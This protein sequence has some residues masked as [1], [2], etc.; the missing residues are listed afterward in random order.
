WCV[1]DGADPW[2][3]PSAAIASFECLSGIVRSELPGGGF[4]LPG[5]PFFNK[6]TQKGH[7]SGWPLHLIDAWQFPTLTWGDPT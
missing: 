5:L 3:F 2:A 7:P 6:Q 1:N 4:A